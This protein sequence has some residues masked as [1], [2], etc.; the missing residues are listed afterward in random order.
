MSNETDLLQQAKQCLANN[1]KDGATQIVA[2]LVKA[3]PKFAQGWL[4]LSQIAFE[5]ARIGLALDSARKAALLT[6]ED[7]ET[8][9]QLG[10]CYLNAGFLTQALQAAQ[11]ADQ[12]SQHNAQVQSMLGT[13]LYRCHEYSQALTCH[14]RAVS[15]QPDNA[16]F[17][18]N[19][20]SSLQAEGRLNE[21]EQA[22]EQALALD[23]KDFAASLALS[24]VKKQTVDN[25]HI[26]T[27]EQN[28]QQQ[29]ESWQ[30]QHR[31][32]YA[33]AKEHEDLGQYQNSFTY[34]QRGSAIKRQHL[35]YDG[36]AQTQLVD[37]LIDTFTAEFFCQAASGLNNREAIFIVGMPR[38]GTTLTE[39]ILASHSEVFAAGELRDF[40][41]SASLQARYQPEDYID[42]NVI[43]R[44]LKT[45]PAALGQRYIEKTRPR[46][47]HCQHFIDKLP[48]NSHYCGLIH[49]A[50][51][52]AKIIVLDRH[53]VDVCF[54]NYKIS[55]NSGYHYSYDLQELAHYYANYQRLMDHWQA[56]LPAEN[57]YRVRYED[58]VNQQEVESRQL[59]EFCGLDW[60]AQCLSFYNNQQ[61]VATASAAQVRQPM[62][63]TSV[64]RWKHYEAQLQPLITALQAYG[65]SV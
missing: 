37:Q 64:A 24:R 10:R 62:Y 31:L 57:F 36:Q 23:P 20:A 44:V 61:G 43:E 65:V 58:I 17:H 26:A 27:L 22:Y 5:E 41:M 8:L 2:N 42:S 60:Q 55:F 30:D 1:D 19:L 32:C 13:L 49:W 4:L 11:K 38:S 52:K 56:V 54:S 21:A 12:L 51:P 3:Y 14:Q 15:L 59:I 29:A 7:G 40:G 46:T 33:L 39:Q 50:L 48:N 35:H 28:L 25:N 63:K 9:L 6:P 45:D 34:L 18:Y 47:G 16:L 53:P